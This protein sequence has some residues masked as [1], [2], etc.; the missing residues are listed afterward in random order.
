MIDNVAK[1][2]EVQLELLREFS[3]VCDEHGLKWY[4][5]FGTLLGAVRY[6]GYLPW[7]DDVDVAMPEADYFELCRHK[8]W[9]G[10]RYFLQ[11]PLDEGYAHF[12]K[13]RKNG[14]TAYN[15]GLWYELRKGGHQGIPIDIIPLSEMF[16]S[17]C[18]HTPCLGSIKRNAVYLKEWFEP[19]GQIMFEGLTLRR[20]AKH[21]K[22]LTEV[23]ENWDW[24]QGA[25]YCHPTFWFFDTETGYEVY[26]KRYT[27]MLEGIEGKK[28]LLFG[29]ADSLRVWLERFGLGDQVVCTFDNDPGKWGKKYYGIDVKNPADIPNMLDD[30]SRLIIVSLWHQEIGR[31]LE[32]M[33]I[34]DYYVY[35][36]TYY[37]EK[38]GNKVVYKEDIP[39]GQSTI[40]R[41]EG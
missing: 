2:R 24:P 4:A 19:A 33:G 22:I 41:W 5:F 35:I 15:L 8:E 18:Y 25:E 7:D 39:Q 28:L 1:L 6:E 32:S 36:N 34:K 30:D 13:L 40:Q 27:G 16:G 10:E 29:A 11:T 31:Q 17:G 37:D 21:R 3:R 26:K 12:A 14:T 9:F 20:P 38:V 23:Y